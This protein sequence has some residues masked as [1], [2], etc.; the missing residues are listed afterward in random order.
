M[1]YLEEA[2]I[3]RDLITLAKKRKTPTA[4]FPVENSAWP[5]FPDLYFSIHPSRK[6]ITGLIEL[7]IIRTVKFDDYSCESFKVHYEP[8][9]QGFLKEHNKINKFCMLLVSRPTSGLY[10][11]NSFE[12]YIPVIHNIWHSKTLDGIFDFI[13]KGVFKKNIPKC[14][15]CG[16]CKDTVF[17][18]DCI[19]GFSFRKILQKEVK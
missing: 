19:Q 15:N 7:K 1:I 18:R 11:F 8:F 16:W 10:L 2:E 14:I 5:G 6:F 9:Q 17:G 13:E 4:V 3:R 12:E